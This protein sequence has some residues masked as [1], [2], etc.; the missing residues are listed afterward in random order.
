MSLREFAICYL[1]TATCF[2]ASEVHGKTVPP[3]KGY[4]RRVPP[5]TAADRETRHKKVTERRSGSLI[6]VHRGASAFAPENTLEAY[7]HLAGQTAR[8]GWYAAHRVGYAG[9]R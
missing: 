2:L 1:L 8:T 3:L 7:A 9:R 4:I 5:E 6:I